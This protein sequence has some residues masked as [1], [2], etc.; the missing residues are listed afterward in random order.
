MST[1]PHLTNNVQRSKT[2]LLRGEAMIFTVKSIT[3]VIWEL[4]LQPQTRRLMYQA[5]KANPVVI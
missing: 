3:T 4:K 1:Q 5:Q 2:D